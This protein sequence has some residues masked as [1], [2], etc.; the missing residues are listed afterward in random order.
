MEKQTEETNDSLWKINLA[1]LGNE[2]ER[3]EA[4]RVPCWELEAPSTSS[5]STPSYRAGSRPATSRS[6]CDNWR[7]P[8][9]MKENEQEKNSA[10]QGG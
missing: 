1:A 8:A 9:N 4:K 3:A 2:Y 6:T 10:L 7:S 5:A